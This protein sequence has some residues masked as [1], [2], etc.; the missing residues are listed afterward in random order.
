MVDLR[1]RAEAII[2]A[3]QLGQRLVLTYRGQ[4]VLAPGSASRNRRSRLMTRSIG[5]PSTPRM[6]AIADQ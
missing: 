4:D 6:A 2:R 1:N 3:V 5:S